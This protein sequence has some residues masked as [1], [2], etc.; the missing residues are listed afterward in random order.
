VGATGASGVNGTN[1]TNGTNGA[2]GASGA[3]GA[4][5]TNGTNGTNGVNG[6]SGATGATGAAGTNGANGTN[7]TNGTNGAIGSTGATGATGASGTNGTNGTNGA[8]GASGVTGRTGA[9]GVAGSSGATGATGPT[10]W[11]V[12]GSN[13]AYYSVG[14]VGIGTA[15]PSSLLSIGGA[16]N[17]TTNVVANVGGSTYADPTLRLGS[18][19]NVNGSGP[20]L[21]LMEENSL[22]YGFDQWYDSG[23]NKLL[24]DVYQGGAAT[25]V[26][27]MLDTGNVGIG[28]ATPAYKLDVNG[29]INATDLKIGGTSMS[30]AYVAKG[31]DTM[32]GGLTVNMG[33]TNSTA[34]TVTSSGAGWGS[35]MIFSN[36]A[37]RNYGIYSDNG[38]A[39]GYLHIVDVTAGADRLLISNTGALGI[40]IAPRSR[41][42]I[43]NEPISGELMRFSYSASDYHTITGTYSG[44]V[45][46]VANM[47]FNVQNGAA[48]STATVMTLRGDGNVGIGTTSPNDKLEVAGVGKGLRLFSDYA[49][50]AETPQVLNTIDFYKHVAAGPNK[51]AS[52][53]TWSRGFATT[54]YSGSDLRFATA[55]NASGGINDRMTI[56]MGGNVGIGTTAPGN[57]LSVAGAGGALNS[58]GYVLH[59][60]GSDG[61]I[62]PTRYMIGFSHGGNLTSGNVRAGIGLMVTS[63]GNGNLVFE[64]G[65]GGAQA[66]RM[67]INGS[68]NV[69]IG[70]N[71]P[72]YMLDVNGT[73]NATDLKIGGTSM[74]AAYVAKSGD[75]MTG[76]LSV[77]NSISTTGSNAGFVLYNRATNASSAQWYSPTAGEVRLYNQVTSAT[78]LTITNA[79]DVG[80]GT[81]TP[82]SKLEVSGGDA[83]I[84]G[85]V[86]YLADTAAAPATMVRSY[87]NGDSLWFIQPNTN[88]SHSLVLADEHSWDRSIEMRY[89][90]GTTGALG[91]RLLIGQLG[92]N[93]ANFTHGITSLYT[94]GTERLRIDSVGNVGIGTTSPGG[95]LEIVSSNQTLDAAIRM[96]DLPGGPAG[97]MGRFQASGDTT[98]GGSYYTYISNGGY[99]VNNGN[100]L[101]FYGD[102]QYVDLQA[103][104]MNANGFHFLTADVTA[105][106]QAVAMGEKMLLTSSGNL[107]LGVGTPLSTV[108]LG[109]G[110][111]GIGQQNDTTPY[112]RMGMDSGYSQY[113]ANNAYWTGTAFN[114]VNA[115]GYGGLASRMAQANGAIM[116]QNA[117]GGVNPITWNT[118][119]FIDNTSNIGIGNS[120]PTQKLHITGTSGATLRIVDGNQAAG[121]VLTS[122]VNG[123]ASWAA[124]AAGIAED[125]SYNIVGGTS[126]FE[127]A[128]ESYNLALVSE[129]LRNMRSS[130]NIG[131]GLRAIR[132]S[133]TYNNN[134][135]GD[136]IGIGTQALMNET[137]GYGNVAIGQNALLNNTTGAESIAIGPSAQRYMQP[138]V[139]YGSNVAIGNSALRGSTTVANNTGNKNVAVGDFTMYNV[140]SAVGNTA[141]GFYAG[142]SALSTGTNNTFLGATAVA[143]ADGSYMTAIG[144]ESSVSTSNTVSI[145]RATDDV[146]MIGRTS[147]N[148]TYKFYV[149]GD[150]TNNSIGGSAAWTNASDARYKKNIRRIEGALDL[151]SNLEGVRYEFNQDRFPGRFEKGTQIGLIAQQIEPFVPEV[152]R[153]EPSGYKGVQY[154]QLVGLLVEALKDVRAKLFEVDDHSR[155]MASLKKENEELKVELQDVRVRLERLEKADESKDRSTPSP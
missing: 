77:G 139:N 116:F 87:N 26:M 51:T 69:G 78:P 60:G 82:G 135:G 54:G 119:L 38:G 72:G 112:M 33:A 79:G 7:G 23:N 50:E 27:T 25:T 59:V 111:I 122:D 70:T 140:T 31:G 89:Y 48:N 129:A 28:V 41:F 124:P 154:A 97:A 108:H 142:G 11:L 128:S 146:V 62:D 21:Q 103:M 10:V 91:G 114:Y 126:A 101:A 90:P 5:G 47:Q 132:G 16:A 67:R 75:T 18:G 71:N 150:G 80:I 118:T 56:A 117:S 74:S 34:M 66:E 93:G 4:T 147:S 92:K 65:G 14:K 144:S 1:G 43:G 107:G 17:Y 99:H 35:G 86:L 120:A 49:A 136:N 131:L 137:S 98:G 22:R 53:Y 145:G 13:D 52:I 64:T 36:T 24:F 110:E 149:E 153:T 12:N 68:G 104:T 155:G 76:A 40:G 143:S 100:E 95:L 148:G 115:A 138:L 61:G 46:S 88:T 125:A 113:I 58:G 3:T 127:N 63:G 83:K 81:V 15:S 30:A 141:I 134:T 20:H 45:A 133:T 57:P 106:G 9:T 32:T 130:S 85:G 105:D 73:I 123:V 37:G 151:V 102:N 94:N 19:A 152:V 121:R 44:S 29:T 84:N 6:A 55:D 39:S 8:A 42:E 2:I 109:R 96:R